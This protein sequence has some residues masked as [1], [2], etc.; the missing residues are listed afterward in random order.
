MP[1]EKEQKKRDDFYFCTDITT[2]SG[3]ITAGFASSVS[4]T[5]ADL[6][7]SAEAEVS[8]IVVTRRRLSWLRTITLL[9]RQKIRKS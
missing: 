4:S 2:Y 8:G 5:D 9:F 6:S 1:Y 7:G 3:S